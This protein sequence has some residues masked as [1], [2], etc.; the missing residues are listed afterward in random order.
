[1]KELQNK[2]HNIYI[3]QNC[4]KYVGIDLKHIILD[5]IHCI[6][7]KKRFWRFDLVVRI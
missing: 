3:L 5:L 2:M 4:R 6:S 1:M 7:K